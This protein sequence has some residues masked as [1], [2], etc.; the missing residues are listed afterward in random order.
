MLQHSMNIALPV[1]RPNTR[2]RR[3]WSNQSLSLPRSKPRLVNGRRCEILHGGL[4]G[5][6]EGGSEIFPDE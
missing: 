5:I 1:I 4:F 6:L 3:S 2:G